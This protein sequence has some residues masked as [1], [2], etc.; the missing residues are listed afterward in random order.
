MSN[1]G[2]KERIRFFSSMGEKFITALKQSGLPY[3]PGF[4]LVSWDEWRRKNEK[5]ETGGMSTGCH[6]GLAPF[7]SDRK[8]N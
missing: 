7:Y 1:A 3:K 8:K 6:A 5:G 2:E 4:E